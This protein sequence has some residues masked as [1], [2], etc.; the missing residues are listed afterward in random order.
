MKNPLEKMESAVSHQVSAVTQQANH[1]IHNKVQA[2]LYQ[3]MTNEK[4]ETV[5]TEVTEKI[6]FSLGKR[7]GHWIV[8]GILGLLLTQ[9]ILLKV[10]LKETCFISHPDPQPTRVT[11]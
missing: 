9:V 6:L 5:L 4:M 3:E 7:Y 1:Q 2:I 10:L 8:L 11:R